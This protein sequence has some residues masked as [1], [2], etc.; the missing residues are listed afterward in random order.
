MKT[1]LSPI[2]FVLFSTLLFSAQPIPYS[3]KVAIRGI[4]FSGEAH[5]TFSLT[6]DNGV[7]KWRN[8]QDAKD[9]IKV[10]IFNGR[11]NV[12]LGG[13]GMNSIPP[14]LFLN[15]NKLFLQ[16]HINQKDGK[17]LQHLGPDQR[18]TSSP[19]SLVAEIAKV[20]ERAKV[21]DTI[22]SGVI[23]K[24]SL[25]S[26]LLD[27]LSPLLKP[28]FSGK[29]PDIVGKKGKSITLQAPDVT[30]AH[31]SY[32]WKKDGVPISGATSSELNVQNDNDHKYTVTVSNAFGSTSE[33][34][35]LRIA[36]GGTDVFSSSS[37]SHFIDENGALWGM[38]NNENGRLGTGNSRF[39][40][41]PIRIMDV[42]V[43]SVSNSYSHTLI[44]KSDGSLWGNGINGEKQIQNTNAFAIN[45]PYQILDSNVSAIIAGDNLSLFI[46]SNG[47]LW[48]MGRNGK[49]QLGSGNT[50]LQENP[51]QIVAKN[52]LA[53]S[54]NY[55]HTMLIKTDGSLW[56]MGW[57]NAGQL[58]DGST[59]DSL[60]P[61]KIV[62]SNVRAIALGHTHSL[63]LKTDGSLWGMG[64]NGSGQLGDGTTTG[65]V[66]PTKLIDSNVAKIA[67]FRDSS[68]YLLK[69]GELWGMGRNNNGQLGTGS[70]SEQI[71]NPVKIADDINR[72][73]AGDNSLIYEKTDGTLWSLGNNS[74][75]QLGDGVTM[76]FP[77]PTEIVSSGVTKLPIKSG[78]TLPFSSKMIVL[79]GQW[80]LIKMA[81]LEMEIQLI[82]TPQ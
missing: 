67:A 45:T 60:V 41:S 11:Y 33:S 25:D 39:H 57:N 65:K 68:Y 73:T 1:L 8:G 55:K 43:S 26:A 76:H 10:S 66:I 58:G 74:F 72:M 79:F 14:E 38:G 53:A 7:I 35:R 63:F 13:Q 21:A 56:G 29:M 51:I 42:N 34:S 71:L 3:G 5:F 15:H 37:F 40:S 31:L 54:S 50:N 82:N 18:I 61:I 32:Q 62:E 2:L 47:S 69:S 4:N 17:G 59:S 64:Q 48:G 12:L 70:V 24:D 78:N 22:S 36:L 6:D 27:H 23:S 19:R 52:V 80:D 44:L 20:A 16:V 77:S 49:G 9:T 46:K 28:S 75:G 81:G 30:G